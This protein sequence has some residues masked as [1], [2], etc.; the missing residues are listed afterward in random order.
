VSQGSRADMLTERQAELREWSPRVTI[1]RTAGQY[2]PVCVSA[3]SR[4]SFWT[5]CVV[6]FE[7]SLGDEQALRDRSVR[8]ALRNHGKRFPLTLGEFGG[9]IL[10]ERSAH[11]AGT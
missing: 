6:G 7:G 3:A 8:E 10:H 2:P 1:A 11:L 5:I 9:R 4:C